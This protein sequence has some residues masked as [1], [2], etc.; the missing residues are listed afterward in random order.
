[1]SWDFGDGTGSLLQN[2]SYVY[3]TPGVYTVTL[4]TTDANG[5]S[6]TATQTVEGY[7]LPVADFD[8]NQG[9]GCS[10]ANITFTDLS[11][12]PA[13]INS[14]FWTFGDGGTATVT[15]PTHNYIADG[16]VGPQLVRGLG[17]FKCC[18]ADNRIIHFV[19]TSIFTW[20]LLSGMG[21]NAGPKHTAR[22]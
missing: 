17:W 19:I 22:L 9:V 2:P 14:W 21:S 3:T 8:A 5:C 4:T 20:S 1:M 12:V 16:F 10:S 13:T 15:N 7:E 6:T 11:T 18:I